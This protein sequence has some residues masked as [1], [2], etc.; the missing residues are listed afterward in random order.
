MVK[1]ASTLSR[2][3]P[4]KVLIIGDLMLDAYTIGKVRRISPEAPVAVVHV[5]HED[6]RP[7]GAGNVVLNLLSLGAQVT[8]VGRVGHDWAGE[9]LC[10]AFQNEKVSTSAIFTQDAYKT[11]IKNRIIADNQQIVRVD[12]EQVTPL[13]EHLEQ[14]IIE[15]LPALIDN[16]KIIAISDYGKGFLTP[17][18]ISAVISLAKE[19][20]IPVIADPKGHDFTKYQGVTIIKPNLSETY[21]AAN[22]PTNAPLETAAKKVLQM[23]QAAILMVTRSEAGISIFTSH[24]ERSDFPAHSREIKDVTGAGDTVLA[25][26]AYALA[27]SLTYGE[28]AQLCNVGASIAIERIGCARVSLTDLAHRLLERDVSNKVFDEDHLFA[29]QEVLKS[30]PYLLLA[31]RGVKDVTQ[32]LYKTIKNIIKE[33]KKR[34]L[35]IYLADDAPDEGLIEM[36]ASLKEVDFILLYPESLRHLCVKAA[37]AQSYLYEGSKLKCL[38]HIN[39]LMSEAQKL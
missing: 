31:L 26:L 18:L 7:G 33:D 3:N 12:Y 24:G 1:L 13:P 39:Q 10:E 19:N 6:N 4:A 38:S 34:H 21:A 32:D 22:L 27:N 36:L 15:S 8:I 14:T 35:L 37:P 9:A 25:I 28:A 29:L 17:T 5:M 23:S 30:K 2:L 16:V 20:N 11:P